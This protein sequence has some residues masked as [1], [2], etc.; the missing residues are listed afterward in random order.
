[1]KTVI[2]S[3]KR[4][5]GILIA[6]ALV[7]AICLGVAAIRQAILRAAG[8]AL[9]VNDPIGSADAIVLALATDEPGV[10][11]TDDL[12]HNGVASRVAVFVDY[13]DSVVAREF[14]RRGADY[15]DD[16]GRSI[17]QLYALGIGNA[18]RIPTFVAGS[19]DEGPTLAEWCEQRGYNSVV[20]VTTT[21][22]SRRL[23]RVLRRAMQGHKA[24]V[25]VRAT[26]YSQFDADRWWK[27]RYGVRIE[28]EEMEKLMLD[29]AR[30]P[31]S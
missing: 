27:S 5:I 25:M 16:A 26:R 6:V 13:P 1:M 12:V 31:L 14:A 22:H 3:H 29:V 18:E 30:H 15:E 23:R 21:D 8:S 24:K 17:R 4:G 10:L 20:V 11:E 7:C 19:E 28:I 2:A 9:V